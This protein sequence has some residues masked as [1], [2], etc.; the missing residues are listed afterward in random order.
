MKILIEN[1][2][3]ELNKAEMNA[4]T[5]ALNGIDIET[6]R[7][8]KDKDLDGVII[9]TCSVRGSA[10]EHV[11]GR[12]GYWNGIKKKNKKFMLIITGCMA[13]RLG[14]DLKKKYKGITAVVKNNDKLSIPLL[15]KENSFDSETSHETYTFAKYY[16]AKGDLNAYIPIMNGCNN[17]CS[18]C[19]V[20]YVRGREVSRSKDDI[21]NEVMHQ[22]KLGAHLITLLGQNVNS[23]AY[24]DENG[25]KTD[26]NTLVKLID[27]LPLKNIKSI[28][29]ES[30]HPKD[31]S[32]ELITTIKNSKHFSHHFHIP[33]QSGS[34]R[35]LELM[36]RRYTREE[37]IGLFKRIKEAIPDATFSMDLMV[38]FPTETKQEFNETLILVKEVNPLDAF[39]YYWN[40]REGTKAAEMTVGVIAENQR[41][42]RLETLIA[43][44]RANALHIKRDRIGME[45]LVIVQKA[46]RDN[47]NEMLGFDI[48]TLEG[49]VFEAKNLKVGTLL[50]VRL[51]SIVGSTYKATILEE[52]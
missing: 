40:K 51:D 36:N 49:V 11:Y 28:R 39:M 35:I 3:C 45:R 33:V 13:D 31:F 42:E 18:Y 22:D 24:K 52:L 43:F 47:P 9:N 19:I 15:I 41:I 26:F 44:Q 5:A 2:G 38:G 6:T 16:A 21:I 48:N 8:T 10:E 30:P 12:I 46:S 4:L 37:V 7:D 32:T 14:D 23:Y 17:F 34:T 29:F 50:K 25:V 1:Y 27:A 20:P